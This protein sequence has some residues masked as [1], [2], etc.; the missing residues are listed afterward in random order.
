MHFYALFY[1]IIMIKG[2]SKSVRFSKRFSP[3]KEIAEMDNSTAHFLTLAASVQTPLKTYDPYPITINE[4][5]S[6]L[7]CTPRNVKFILRKLEDNQFIQWKPGRGRGHISEI[8][9]LSSVEAVLEDSLQ[10]LIKKGKMKDAIELIGLSEVNEPLKERLLTILNKQMGFRIEWEAASGLDVLRITRNRRMEKLDP[11]FVVSAF[12]SYVLVQICNTLI[13]YDSTSDTF[14]P[15]LAH[16][17]ETNKEYTS[18][19]FYLRKGVRFHHGRI[20]TSRDVKDTYQR[21]LNL[22]SPALCHYQDIKNVELQ[23]DYRIRYDLHRSNQFFL[24][25]FS[26]VHMSI[27][28]YDVDFSQEA[29]G[30]GPYRLQN[31]SDKALVLCAFD[32]YFGMRPLLDKVE[33]WYLPEQISHERQYQLPSSEIV[34]VSP[35]HSNNC[36]D[37]PALGCRYLLFNFHR[38]GILHN[39]L[40]RQALGILYNPI[41]LIRELGGNRIT[42]A[43]SFLPWISSQ[44]EWE[45]PILDKAK[46][47][48]NASGYQGEVITLAFMTKLEES[49]EAE[50]LMNRC[51]SIGL[52]IKLQPVTEFNPEKVS[53]IADLLIAEEILEDDW[54]WGMIH[55]FKNTSNHLNNFLLESQRSL[56][57]R[58]LTDF[59]QLPTGERAERL[60][61]VEGILRDQCWML[62]GCHINKRAQLNQSLFGVQTGTYGFLDISKMWI[63]NDLS[64]N[65]S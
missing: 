13:T 57:N 61:Q 21:L 50:W 14:L 48:L 30:T 44:R 16:M 18:Y 6:I 15:S 40:F 65:G 32:Y 62:Y 33:I 27:L 39:F 52:Q 49:E 23:G 17:W 51:A 26:C 58:V 60:D 19:T 11:A 64:S 29:I 59:T 63:K 47:L 24:H 25:L 1:I 35:D 7:C 10:D 41:H 31:L 46:E 36:I 54:Q 37:Y 53:D 3:L 38:I 5:A 34:N 9:F 42:P 12:Q 20:L 45:E 2:E 43:D 55:Y 8:T 28:P 22:N 56:L 4:I